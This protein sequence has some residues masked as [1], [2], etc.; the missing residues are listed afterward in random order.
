[1]GVLSAALLL[2]PAACRTKSAGYAQPPPDG[3]S[4]TCPVS[5][6]QCVKGPLTPAAVYEM[7]TFYFCCEDCPTRF[8]E[9]P[10]R[11]AAPAR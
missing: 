10:E 4:V 6:R 11:Y 8:A 2:A 3:T 9:A 5:G 7:H 1:M